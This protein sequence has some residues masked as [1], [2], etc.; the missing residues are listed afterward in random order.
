MVADVVADVACIMSCMMGCHESGSTGMSMW[1]IDG[2]SIPE[3]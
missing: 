1:Y 2:M 3:L